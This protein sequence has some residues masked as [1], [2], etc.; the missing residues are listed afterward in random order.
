MTVSR[1]RKAPEAADSDACTRATR[2]SP[3]YHTL[4]TAMRPGARQ[5]AKPKLCHATAG[6]PPFTT[7]AVGK[8]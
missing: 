2:P 8:A 5:P 3:R 6:Q 4:D 1:G 7:V